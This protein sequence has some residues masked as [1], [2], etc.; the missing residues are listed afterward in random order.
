MF[1]GTFANSVLSLAGNKRSL[2]DNKGKC[3]REACGVTGRF[4][5]IR[6]YLLRWCSD[7]VKAGKEPMCQ[8][9]GYGAGVWVVEESRN[10]L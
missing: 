1:V 5:A 6:D 10:D 2:E 9:R 7:G 3:K 8:G 4:Y